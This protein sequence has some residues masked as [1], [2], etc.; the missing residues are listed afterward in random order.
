[1]NETRLFGEVY[2]HYNPASGKGY[3][4]QTTQGTAQ[5]WSEH[6]LHSRSPKCVDF[7]YPLAR[8]I[9]KHGPEVFEHQVLSVA[10]TKAELDNLEKVWIILLNTRE[11][12]YNLGAGGEGNLG[13]RH[14]AEAKAKISKAHLGNTS[15]VGRS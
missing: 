8:A 1:M 5:R 3:V 4:G 9:N 7:K 6:V 2:F 13:L 10:R 12:G 11:T 15:C 14:T